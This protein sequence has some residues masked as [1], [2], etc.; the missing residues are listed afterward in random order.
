MHS[1]DSEEDMDN[2][3]KQYDEEEELINFFR[4]F[5]P[6][7]VEGMESMVFSVTDLES[8]KEKEKILRE[9]EDNKYFRCKVKDN[10][11][12]HEIAAAI[13]PYLTD[14]K[15]KQLAHP[16][17]TQLNEAMNN[18]VASYAPKNKN[19][20]GT[21]P[22]RARV[23]IAGSIMALGHEE[24]W[25]R[26]FMELNLEMDTTFRSTLRDRDNKK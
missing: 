18:S 21:M 10:E 3:A 16:W 4:D 9:K 17:S 26:V 25:E 6:K 22:L 14:E 1:S 20:C 23:G 5:V 15:L 2:Y 7:T 24:F 11:L 12:Y 13:A 8:L 19:F